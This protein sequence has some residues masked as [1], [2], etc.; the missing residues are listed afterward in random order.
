MTEEHY[1]HLHTVTH[2]AV[3][4]TFWEST[5]AENSLSFSHGKMA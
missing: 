2:G 5:A 4:F 3:N 1:K